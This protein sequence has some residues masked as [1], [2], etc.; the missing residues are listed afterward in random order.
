MLTGWNVLVSKPAKGKI[1]FSPPIASR[2]A[3][4]SNQPA[5]HWILVLF[6]SPEI[7]KPWRDAH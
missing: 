2:P 1:F 4:D 7:K 6:F 3:L 5:L